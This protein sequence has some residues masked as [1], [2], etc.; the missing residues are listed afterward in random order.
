MTTDE[1]LKLLRG[2][3]DGIREWNMRR[4]NGEGIPRLELVDFSL[5]NLRGADLRGANLIQARGRSRT[6]GNRC[7]TSGNRSGK[8]RGRLLVPQI[9][10]AEPQTRLP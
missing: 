8:G 7:G 5:A 4:E 2:G 3:E 6:S 1:A 9:P 10:F